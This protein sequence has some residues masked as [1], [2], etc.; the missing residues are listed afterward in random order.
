MVAMTEFVDE[1][2]AKVEYPRR[3]WNVLFRY[4]CCGFEINV[5][6]EEDFERREAVQNSQKNQRKAEVEGRSLDEAVVCRSK[7]L[8]PWSLDFC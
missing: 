7:I 4:S 1:Q 2:D 5:Q 3:C 6:Y 8:V